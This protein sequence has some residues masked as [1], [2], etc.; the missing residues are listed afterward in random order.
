[1][2]PD[3]QICRRAAESK[4]RAHRRSAASSRIICHNLT[5]TKPSRTCEK[6]KETIVKIEQGRE[7]GGPW[8]SHSKV[9]IKVEN[10]VE[11]EDEVLSI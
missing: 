3:K 11:R 4:L 10:R 7:H 9:K 1:M 2:L 5:D 8:L 6:E